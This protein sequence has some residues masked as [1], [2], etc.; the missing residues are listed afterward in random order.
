MRSV[1]PKLGG[2]NYFL[3]TTYPQHPPDNKA[4]PSRK[5]SKLFTAVAN[6]NLGVI[7]ASLQHFIE[8]WN[9]RQSLS[10]TV[11]GDVEEPESSKPKLRSRVDAIDGPKVTF[12]LTME[13]N[14]TSRKE[15][16]SDWPNINVKRRSAHLQWQ[17]CLQQY[18][19]LQ[20][21]PVLPVC[22]L[23][24]LLSMNVFFAIV[25]YVTE[26]KCCDDIP[27][28]FAEIFDFSL[29]TSSTIGCGGYWTKDYFNNA[30]VVLIRVLSI[31]RATVYG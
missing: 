9:S 31:C 2:R 15:H 16:L 25:W 4:M 17:H 19:M 22:Y 14:Q 29:Q 21:I 26:Y 1:G 5:L 28:T 7:V 8:L 12:V 30:L 13:V 11:G 10:W 6:G 20:S 27:M 24:I 18:L 3:A 23:I